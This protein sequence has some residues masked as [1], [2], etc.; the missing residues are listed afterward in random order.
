MARV[1]DIGIDEV[2]DE[3]HSLYQRFAAEYKLFLSQVNMFAH[4]SAAHRN[5]KGL[6]LKMADKLFMAVRHL[7][8]PIVTASAIKR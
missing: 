2:D 6:L 1:R 5:I 7:E 8:I 3:A 4:R